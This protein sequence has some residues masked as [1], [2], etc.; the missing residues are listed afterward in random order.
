MSSLR[1]GVTLLLFEGDG[2][3]FAVLRIHLCNYADIY[4]DYIALQATRAPWLVSR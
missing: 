2:S 3:T 4:M 1:F